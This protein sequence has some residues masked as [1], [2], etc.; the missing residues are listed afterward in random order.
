MSLEIKVT[1]TDVEGIKKEIEQDINEFEE[2]FQQEVEDTP[3]MIVERSILRTYL[4]KK[5]IGKK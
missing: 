5:T 3:L 1:A 4:H 2:W